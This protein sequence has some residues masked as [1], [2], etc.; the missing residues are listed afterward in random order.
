MIC[1]CCNKESD[2]L[3]RINPLGDTG[4][5]YCSSCIDDHKQAI[6]DMKLMPVEE[7]DKIPFEVVRW[8]CFVKGCKGHTK[9]RDYGAWPEYWHPRKSIGWFSIF[10]YY[11]LCSKHNKLIK[12]L[13]K[14][15][16]PE[17]TYEQKPRDGAFFC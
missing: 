1:A 8:N 14:I 9:V 12:R 11:W 7:L 3:E 15:Y 4:I 6:E 16:S 5:F 10:Q 13:K 17:L 2:Y